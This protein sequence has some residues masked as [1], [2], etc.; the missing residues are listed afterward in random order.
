MNIEQAKSRIDALTAELN[1]HNHAYYVLNNPSISDYEF[2]T[3]LRELQELESSFPQFADPNSP[4]KRVGGDITDKFEKVKH[5]FPMLSLSNTYSQEEI[6]DWENRV[7]KLIQGEVEYVLELKYDGVAISMTYEDGALV[8]AVTRGDG[9]VGEDVTTNVKTIRSVPLTLHGKGYPQSFDIRGE[10]YF[11]RA[12]FEKLNV[13]RA[14]DGEELYANPRNTASGTLKNQ[15]SK[16]VASRGLNC[17]LYFVYAEQLPFDNHF[18][19]LM[20]AADWGFRVPKAADRYIERVK[21]VDGIM[22]FIAHWDKNR[23]DLPFEIDGIVIKVNRYDQQRQLGM[24]AKSPRWATS[25]K[26]KAEKVLTRLNEITYQVGRT[27]A[28]TPVANLEPVLLAGTTVRRASLH[29]ADQIEKFDIRE[30]DFVYVEKGGEII[31]KVVGVELSK[32]NPNS[33]PH[34]YISNCPECNT[35][36]VRNDGEAQHYCPNENGCGPQ[37]KGRIEH[38]IARKAMNIDGMGPETV[39]QLWDAGLL[40]DV[41]SLYA[42]RSE[43]LLPLER[44]AERSVEKLL[45]GIEASKNQPFERVLFA[46]GIRHIGETVAKKLARHFKSLDALMLADKEELLHVEEIGDKIADS[47]LI[48]FAD[49]R[50]RLIL[51]ALKTAGLQFTMAD[52]TADGGSQVLEGKSFVVSGVFTAFSRDEIKDMIEKHGGRNVGSISAKTDFVLAGENMGPS[53]LKKAESLSI[54]IISE[55][56][57]LGMIGS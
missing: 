35:P 36:L 17:F 12:A 25:F 56:D 13:Q 20:H 55:E 6:I 40:K 3:L 16:L 26:F 24:T 34:L 57:F 9:D 14:E 22:E 8:R 30:G 53:K 2:D 47:L 32:R 45:E 7:K 37:L 51:D 39:E 31:P 41:S 15:D 27:G 52:N 4:S 19:S 5:R 46:L 38:F 42:L 33:V 1:G 28:I 54:P 21:D 29:N 11:P 23:H 18:E 10:I 50:N 44:M 48:Y 43:Q 49:D